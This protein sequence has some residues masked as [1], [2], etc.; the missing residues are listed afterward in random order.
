MARVVRANEDLPKWATLK[1]FEILRLQPG[2][3]VRISD[4]PA[5]RRLVVAAGSGQAAGNNWS[6]V[7]GEGQFFDTPQAQGRMTFTAAQRITELVV[8]E[9]VW[10][11]E[12]GGCGLFQVADEPAPSDRGE[13]W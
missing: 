12:L 2:E 5:Q 9:G 1:R 4:F 7:L 6:Q 11:N 8:L 3:S 10:G 13:P